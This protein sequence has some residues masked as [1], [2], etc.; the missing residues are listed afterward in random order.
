M[1]HFYTSIEKAL[2]RTV[3]VTSAG[4]TTRKK[5]WEHFVATLTLTPLSFLSFTLIICNSLLYEII[6]I[7]HQITSYK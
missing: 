7:L 1:S 5:N 3:I 2:Y 4:R 6:D